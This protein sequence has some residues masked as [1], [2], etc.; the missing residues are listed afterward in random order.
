MFSAEEAESG[1]ILPAG[2]DFENGRVVR[3][4][5]WER[6]S[7][8][9]PGPVEKVTHH[10]DSAE[11]RKFQ[12]EIL[13]IY[14]TELE[15]QGENRSQ[16][17]T[18]QD[19]FD[20]I[21]WTEEDARVQRERGQEP[22]VF[23]VIT[24]A[25][26]W[27]L[28][29]EKRGRTDFKVLP[30]RKAD[31][32]PARRKTELLKYLSDVNRTPFHRSRAFED[33]AKVGVGWLEDGYTDDGDEES[34]YS[35]YESWRNMIFDSAGT[36]N[37]LKDCR[38]VF[39]TRWTD[40]DVALAMFP[41]RREAILASVR[42][43]DTWGQDNYGDDAMDSSENDM[44]NAVGSTHVGMGGTER[45]RV[46][47]VEGWIRR[48]KSVKQMKGGQFRGE[49]FDEFSP[50]HI[51][52]VNT[53]DSML[54][55]KMMM[56]M[57]VCIFTASHI[58][59]YGQSP[60]RHNKFPFTP[61][62]CYRRGRD[63]M[64]YG[65]IRGM[66]DIQYDINK[67]AAKALYILST[68]K[69]VMDEG[70]VDNID[71]L[72]EEV[73]R[74]DA[75]IVKKK[76]YDLE[77]NVERDL[78]A[79][80]LELMRS[81]Q[82]MIQ[83][84]SGVTDEL[85]GRTTN[86]TSG[87][88]IGLRQDQGSMATA[89]IF[90][91]LRFANQIQGEKQLS[92]IEQFYTEEKEFRITDMRGT[93]EYISVN[94]GE[95][96]N[97]ITRTKSDFIISEADWRASIRQS[98]AEELIAMM[99]QLAPT[100]PQLAM[101]MLDLIVEQMDIPNREEVVKRIRQVT[102]MRD[103]DA[104]EPTPEELQRDQAQQQQAQMQQRAAMADILLKEAQVQ[105]ATADAG[106][107]QAQTDQV[108]AQ[109][110]TL[111]GQLAGTNVATQM[112]ALQAA[113]AMISAPQ[114]V[115]MADSI[116][117]ESGFQSRTEQETMAAQQQAAQQQAMAQQAQQEQMAQQ[118]QAQQQQQAAEQQAMEQQGQPPQPQPPLS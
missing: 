95:Q 101:V 48:P 85:L 20:N 82:A 113:I 107:S 104:E 111:V 72:R 105:K 69:V 64:P 97:D 63:G 5:A 2:P 100:A 56:R 35:R 28:G 57:H 33:C 117:H 11:A 4:D 59:Y 106:K 83:T 115:P 75:I 66:R 18:D 41:E 29:S 109:A 7:L 38:Y 44:N 108:A 68:N 30:R 60:Y 52:A 23:N 14:Q 16:M 61:I 76:G 77:L 34:V 8:A 84:L 32:K 37:D 15:R 50:G 26:N 49:V 17:A 103:P 74:P 79:A 102:G 51:D 54:A 98:N 112:A 114:V 12:R 67:R 46:R 39:R 22:L 92:L 91:N 9:N 6:D 21:Q 19:Y 78:A 24:Q 87:K 86:A 42:G 36:E 62:W 27:V 53:G 70:A 31:G 45:P 58:L 25:I 89:G 118:E 13:N 65:M 43:D 116:L 80:H 47:L 90:D 96:E 73:S 55:E 93:P 110:Q 99:T 3:G 40:L 71:E 1:D 81:S 10:L 94:N 88:A